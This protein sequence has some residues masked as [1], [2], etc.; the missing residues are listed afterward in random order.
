MEPDG[1]LIWDYRGAL[2]PDALPKKLI[3]I[4]GDGTLAIAH[5]FRPAGVRG[6]VGIGDGDHLAGG[7]QRPGDPRGEGLGREHG[8]ARR[9]TQR[10]A[11]LLVR[12]RAS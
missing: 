2:A 9:A 4:G 1:K 11:R 10:A 12:L 5:E 6:Q 7:D 8:V 3:V